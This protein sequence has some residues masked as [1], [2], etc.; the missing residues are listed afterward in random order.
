MNIEAKLVHQFGVVSW[1][2]AANGRVLTHGPSSSERPSFARGDASRLTA[3][4]YQFEVSCLPRRAPS[5]NILIS[6]VVACGQRECIRRFPSVLSARNFTSIR[7]ETARPWTPTGLLPVELLS[8]C[9]LLHL[10]RC[11]SKCFGNIGLSLRDGNASVAPDAVLSRTRRT[12]C[13]ESLRRLSMA[14]AGP[15]APGSR[16]TRSD[17]LSTPGAP[18]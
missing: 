6:R 4:V 15:T 3:E 12:R 13:S 17:S 2:D 1:V 14:G 11:T 9:T 5:F 8:S 16:S 7:R 10:W 18:A